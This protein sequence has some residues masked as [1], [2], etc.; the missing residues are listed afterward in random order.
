MNP[1][2]ILYIDV[3]GDDG[4]VH[5]WRCDGWP[6]NT[7]INGGMTRDMLNVGDNV[8]VTGWLA[9]EAQYAFSGREMRMPDGR[10]FFVGPAAS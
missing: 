6:P 2:V 1:H 7:I 9:R 5:N 4:R 3:Q 8:T 10:K